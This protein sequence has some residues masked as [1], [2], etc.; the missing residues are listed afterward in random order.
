MSKKKT[1]AERRPDNEPLN[2]IQGKRL[3][4]LTGLPAAELTGH[5]VAELG[6]KLRWRFNPDLFLFEQVCGQ[7]VKVDPVTGLKY[8]VPGATVNFIDTDCDW[9]W[10]FPSGWP[11]GWIFPWGFCHQEI[12]ATTTTDACGNFCVWIPRFDID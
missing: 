9:L 2:P 12:L 3:A 10:F 1:E 8:P 7:V 11:W 5:S 4:R 6:E